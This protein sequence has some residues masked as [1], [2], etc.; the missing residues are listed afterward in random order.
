MIRSAFSILTV[1][2][3]SVAFAV[4]DAVDHKSVAQLAADRMEAPGRG[5]KPRH[6]GAP[7]A[8]HRPDNRAYTGI[9]SVEVAPNGR[10]WATWFCGITPKE[11]N[12]SYVVLSTSGDGGRTWKE[13]A[14]C[15]PDAEGP[16][17]AIDPMVWAA[18]DG[19]LRWTWSEY[20]YGEKDCFARLTLKGVIAA[21]AGAET[22]R[23]RTADA[24]PM[25]RGVMLGDPFVF[26]D[27]T[28]ALPVAE[29]YAD[30]SA[31]L[32]VSTDRGE[33]WSRRG[34]LNIPKPY[35]DADEHQVIE[36]KDGRLWC[37]ARTLIGA[38]EGF[39]SDGG[40]T[41]TAPTR[42]WFH[43]PVS[44]LAAKRLRSG[45]IVMVK[46]GRARPHWCD[47]EGR[48]HLWACVSKDEGK[49]WAGEME[50]EPGECSYPNLAEG[51]DGT[52]YVVYD[53]RRSSDGEIRFAA[54]REEDVLGGNAKSPTV[55]LRQLVTKSH[56]PRK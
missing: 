19:T 17:R 50:I 29:W 31:S 52:I 28:W 38:V 24:R 16:A 42:P 45:S 4:T 26:R 2:G 14:V 54:F 11:D 55:R 12:N 21:D 40:R 30:D 53:H 48:N 13:V 18:P 25:M 35:R 34:G 33:T 5:V 1:L 7:R 39:S 9:P 56:A 6:F 27:G 49:T 37:L 47:F 8:D 51:P 44:R 20:N 36:L 15:D 41:W 10:L 3:F 32:W 23:W 22:P 46:H 43:Q